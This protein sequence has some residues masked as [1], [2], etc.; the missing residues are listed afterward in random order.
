MYKSARIPTLVRPSW[1][2]ALA[3]SLGCTQSWAQTPTPGQNINMVSGTTLPGGDPFLQRQNE[4]SV[5]VSSR[6]NGHLLAGANDY[7]TVDLP[8]S[9]HDQVPGTLAG[10][11]WLSYFIS[12]DGAQTWQSTLLPGFP[13]D[14]SA[15]GLASP[16]KGFA[17]AADP[18]VRAGTHGMF[19]YSGIVFDRNLNRGAI[20]VARFIDLNNKENGNAESSPIQYIDTRVVD[21]GN[22]G[23]FLDKP[24]IAVD[25]PRPGGPNCS[26]PVTPTQNIPAGTVYIVWSRFTGANSTKIMISRSTNCGSSWSNPSKL[27]ESNSINQGTNV[28]VDPVSGAVYVVWRRFATR[29]QGD[30]ILF[31]RSDDFGQRFSKAREVSSLVPFDQGTTTGSFRTNALPTL[32]VSVDTNGLSR[33]H[34]AWADRIVPGGDARIVISSSLEGTSWSGKVPVDDIPIDSEFPASFNPGNR[35]H[36]FMP[37]LT[38]SA[39]QLLALY[40][41]SRLDHTTGVFEPVG[42]SNGMFGQD[43]VTGE[44]YAHARDPRGELPGNPG[45]VFTPLLDDTGLLLRRHTLDLRLAQ[46]PAGPALNFTHALVSRYD[47][48]TRGDLEDITNSNTITAMQQLQFNPPNLPLFQQGSVPFIGDYID[49]AGQTFLPPDTPNGSWRFNSTPG[50]EVV[51]YA[52]WTS[53]QDVR[54]PAPPFTWSDFTPPGSPNCNPVLTGTRNQNVYSSRI[55]QGLLVTAPQNSKPL[56]TTLTRTFVILTQNLTIFD[57]SFLL[58]VAAQPTGGQASFAASGPVAATLDVFIPAHSGVARSL[59]VTSSDSSARIDVDVAETS[60][61]GVLLPGG[62]TGFVVL[63]P[64]PTV[65]QLVNPDGVGPGQDITVIEIYNP[66]I[67]NPNISN[68]NVANPNI[69]NPNISNPN[70]VNPNLAHPNIANP[71]IVNPNIVNPN[72]ANPNIA[73]PNIANPNIANPNIA[74][75]NISNQPVS[76]ATY[77]LTN[78]GNTTASYS[79]QL[80]GTA[81]PNT[82]LQLLVN[83]PYN[84]PVAFGCQLDVQTQNIL[85]ANVPNA[86]FTAPGSLP[87]DPN[88]PN[89]G[90]ATFSLPPGGTALITLR[91]SITPQEIQEVASMSAPVVVAQGDNTMDAPLVILTTSLPDGNVGQTYS[92]SVMKIGGVDPVV[93]S[94]ASGQFPPGLVLDSSTGGI[95]GSPTSAGAFNFSIQVADSDSPQSAVQRFFSI[96][97]DKASTLTTITSDTPNPS[98]VGQPVTVAFAVS[99]L[100]PAVGT[101]TGTVTVRDLGGQASCTATVAAGSCVLTINSAGAKTL[102]ATYSGDSNFRGSLGDAGHTVNSPAP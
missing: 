4:P 100:A 76:D 40:Y 39:G 84:T 30:S 101:P 77:T 35:G 88:A 93:W 12:L 41:D 7:R 48:G 1:V 5:A 71:N 17:A 37:Q 94:V 19:Y 91:G 11:A 6:S 45:A 59:F 98:L 9:P 50:G 82:S 2:I 31:A 60:A 24:W 58:S 68:P 74:N 80:V 47:F 16:L 87:L 23:Q 102:V 56:S 70:V 86:V 10:D 90:A 51:H 78:E 54:P 61:P 22:A 81:P 33:I 72:I 15:R 66:N 14:N 62:L 34:V 36:Q 3:L 69:A 64:D 97:V 26:I 96:N 63:N 83:Q 20:F 18:T 73:N 8:T 43:P 13:Q 46:A 67:S 27:S 85:L 55:T 65:P 52:V 42:Q 57:R 53:N 99:P 92:S 49:I 29:S 21:N 75:P 38:F 89:S 79:I 28:V 25:I 32:A 95:S 44:F